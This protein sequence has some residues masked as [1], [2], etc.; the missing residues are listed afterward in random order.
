MSSAIYQYVINLFV[1]LPISAG[2]DVFVDVS[3]WEHRP[4]KD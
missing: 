3:L 2:P 4:L 1:S